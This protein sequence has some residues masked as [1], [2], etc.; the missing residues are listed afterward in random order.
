MSLDE[1]VPEDHICRVICVFTGHLDMSALGYK[2]AEV[3]EVGNR[4]YDPRM[5]LNL[6]RYGFLNR[7]RSSRRLESET[8]RNVEVMWLMDGLTP[9][10][11]TISNFR[12]DNA[13]A[14]RL[15][16]REFSRMCRALGLYGGEA[17]A[18]DS[19]KIRANNSRKNNHN[20]TTV[21]RELSRIDKKISEYLNALD[22]A[23]AAGKDEMAP[24]AEQIKEALKKLNE[25]K[26]KYE[27]FLER[28]EDEGEISTVDPD[29]R[30]MKQNGD[31][32]TLD[33]CYNVQTITD[34]KHN[35]I[36]DFEVTNQP[37]DKGNLENMSDRAMEVM[38]VETLTN[39]A[40][41][42]YY[43]GEDIAACEEKGVT[44]LVAKPKP[45]GAK[46]AEGFS[47]YDFTYN[48]ENDCYICP[49]QNKLNFMRAQKHS[50]GKDYRVYANYAACNKCPQKSLCTKSRYRQILRPPY[51]DTMDIVDARTKRNKELY[52]KR[53]E[54]VEHPF[55]T[56]KAVWGYRQFLCRTKPKVTAETALAYLAYNLRRV[57]NIFKQ[58]GDNFAAVIAG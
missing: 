58:N 37:D 31:G 50:N 8:H 1:Y 41:K 28:L 14:L 38:E 4:P 56:I 21:E 30:L 19:V 18:T 29:S 51:Q 15:T 36:V 45:G 3:K 11:K 6:Y 34:S 23:D 49:M 53:Q 16:F 52:R 2:Y 13:K 42:G 55:G 44:C 26:E 10:D 40:D 12:K 20:Q 54:I 48:K 47:L 7:V 25:R 33:V 24:T 39:L 5:M 32:R 46:M 43:D 17:A 27:G 57:F 9:D 35:L 22:Q